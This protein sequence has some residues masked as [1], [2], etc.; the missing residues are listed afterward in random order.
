MTGRVRR[1]ARVC[2]RCASPGHSNLKGH[3]SYQDNKKYIQ[4][5]Q[6]PDSRLSTVT[7]PQEPSCKYLGTHARATDSNS[8]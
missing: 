3:R 5:V 7:T 1:D 6:V 8:E 4:L 2:M